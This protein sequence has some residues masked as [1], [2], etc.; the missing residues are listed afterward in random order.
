M[1]NLSEYELMHQADFMKVYEACER[2][3]SSGEAANEGLEP[4]IEFIYYQRRD[5]A[6]ECPAPK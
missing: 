1:D 2:T 3:L 6:G 5:V 4:T